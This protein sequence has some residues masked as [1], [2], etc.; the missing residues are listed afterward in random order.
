MKTKTKLEEINDKIT[1]Q[2]LHLHNV[3]GSVCD[4]KVRIPSG[5]VMTFRNVCEICGKDMRKQTDR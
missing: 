4:H 1:E 2:A 3:S 5:M